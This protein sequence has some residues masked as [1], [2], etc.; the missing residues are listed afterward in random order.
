MVISR[1]RVLFPLIVIGI[2]AMLLL[3]VLQPAGELRLRVGH[4]Q[5]VGSAAKTTS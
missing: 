5:L 4:A 2:A 3:L 1:R